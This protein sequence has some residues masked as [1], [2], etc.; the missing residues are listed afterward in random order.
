MI[1][2]GNWI[3]F[4]LGIIILALGVGVIS[5]ADLGIGSWDAINFGLQD[6][7]GLRLGTIMFITSFIVIILS[8]IIRKSRPRIS[9]WFTSLVIGVAV[10]FWATLLGNI[11]IEQ[12]YIR[13]MVFAIGIV[14][15]G[16][17]IAI[18]LLAKFPPNP[19][20]DF[21]IALKEKFNLK[22]GQAKVLADFICI[23]VA[24]IIGGPIG[25]GTILAA[26]S[27]GPIVNIVFNKWQHV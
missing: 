26:I 14:I 24:L 27:V 5:I 22:I 9:T 1:K 16:I 2:I 3:K 21:M 12:S 20:D 4:F 13:I 11:E 18:Y 10:D 19:I 6:L 7:S 15:Q 25:I 17:G 23:I 8:S